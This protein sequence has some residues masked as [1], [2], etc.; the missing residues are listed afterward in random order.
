M[1][2]ARSWRKAFCATAHTAWLAGTRGEGGEGRWGVVRR[3]TGAADA[4]EE[5]DDGS[6]SVSKGEFAV[7]IEGGGLADLGRG[8]D[9]DG[10]GDG[11]QPGL[12]GQGEVLD[13]HPGWPGGLVVV[14]VEGG[15]GG[16]RGFLGG[17]VPGEL[18]G[19]A[20]DA[21]LF[22]GDLGC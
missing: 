19:V 21:G 13:G 8:G 17:V 2:M 22:Q 18:E 3:R 16:S 15:G 7:A 5:D 1:A 11:G 9:G 4:A 12:D 20:G 10:R 14:G 6:F